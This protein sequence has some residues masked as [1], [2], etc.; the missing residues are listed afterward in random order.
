LFLL[1]VDLG[2]APTQTLPFRLSVVAPATELELDTLDL[3]AAIQ[4]RAYRQAIVSIPAAT[5]LRLI[6]GDLPPGLVLSSNSIEGTPSAIGFWE[7]LVDVRS[8]GRSTSRRYSI[9]VGALFAPQLDAVV[10]S[11]SYQAGAVAP[12]EILALFG[13]N[14]DG[15]RALIN[16]VPA[17]I[18][19]TTPTQ[20]S[21]IVPFASASR[22]S[23]DLILERAGLQSLP[24][25]LR[26]AGAKPGIY[27]Q[28][29]SGQGP[30]AALNQDG[31]LNTEANAAG[32]VI[33]VYG[34]GLGELEGSVIDGTPAATA[35][36]AR[37]FVEKQL[38]ATLD[39]EEINVLYAGA[40][41]GL[42]HGASQVNLQLPSTLVAGKHRLRL[43]ARGRQSAEVEFWVK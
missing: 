2:A 26:I 8:G 35:S 9:S 6:E 36:L 11:A 23:V 32:S 30:A 13:L 25:R 28:N 41:P 18:L 29:G 3:P 5:S 20:S 21:I 31:S 27:T 14:L 15:I 7:F 1:R 40:A 34:T 16:G 12:G 17:P 19:Y 37:V 38:R 22:D 33:V 4:N 10:N 42:I 24:L 39:G 43:S